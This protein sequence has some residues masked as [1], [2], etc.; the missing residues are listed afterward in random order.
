MAGSNTRT[1]LGALFI[2]AAI[3]LGFTSIKTHA[4]DSQ[5]L[6]IAYTSLGISFGPL[7]LTKEAGI[8]KKYDI[9]AELLYIAGGP[10][11]TQALIGGDVGIAL[12][13]AGALIS[14]NLSGSDVVILGATIRTLPFQLYAISSIKEPAQLHGTKLGVSRLGATSDFVAR[15]LLKKW[16]L[17]PDKDVAIFQTG[18]VPQIFVAMEGGS[19]QSGILSTGPDTLRADAEGYTLLADVSTLGLDYPLGPFGVRRASLDRQPQLIG[20]FVKAYIEGIHR[21][22]T[23]KASAL[24]TL[25]KY[26]KQKVTPASEKVYEVYA[27]KYIQKVPEATPAAIQTILDEIS[28][29]R[30]LPQGVTPQRFIEPKFVRELVSSGFVDG[31]Y[32]GR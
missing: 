20:R 8:F 23:D 17:E 19:I 27:A 4:A 32:R 6:R 14:S 18:S 5:R 10:L 30:P 2:F 13:S 1:R 28:A 7:W 9:D 21:F 16:G 22:K 11:A 24:A 26:M 3:I 29:R 15:Y 31:L 12:A 25:E